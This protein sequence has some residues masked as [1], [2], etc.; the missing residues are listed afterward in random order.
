MGTDGQQHRQPCTRTQHCTL[1]GIS[2]HLGT[3]R[4]LR[5]PAHTRTHADTALC[6]SPHRHTQSSGR[7]HTHTL[8]PERARTAA[9]PRTCGSRRAPSHPRADLAVLDAAPHTAPPRRSPHPPGA[10]APPRALLPAQPRCAQ[11]GRYRAP[12]SSNGYRHGT[13]G[14]EDGPRLRGGT[15]APL[16]PHRARSSGKGRGTGERRWR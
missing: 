13:A 6:A 1:T 16:S 2:A 14:N 4:A 8:I 10:E 15:P 11:R 7:A 5:Q 3:A 9:P 12:H